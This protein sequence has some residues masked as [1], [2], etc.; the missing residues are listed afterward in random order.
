MPREIIIRVESLETSLSILSS[1]SQYMVRLKHTHSI[2]QS[3]QSLRLLST[4]TSSRLCAR[5]RIHIPL[6]LLLPTRL[7][8]IRYFVSACALLLPA[9]LTSSFAASQCFRPT[10]L[11]R[12]SSSRSHPSASYILVHKT[13]RITI[14]IPTS[15]PLGSIR[16]W[17]N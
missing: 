17:R 9:C 10:T 11:V 1:A 12:N 14:T 8:A 5:A 16:G 6:L 2:P 4:T 13:Y 7:P 15:L 3:D